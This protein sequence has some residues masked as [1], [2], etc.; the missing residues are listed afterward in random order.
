MFVWFMFSNFLLDK[1]FIYYGV[2]GIGGR[3][4]RGVRFIV[5]FGVWREMVR[6]YFFYDLGLRCF[7][8]LF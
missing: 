2:D 3:E 6:G 4:V 1:F 8:S 5:F 7:Y